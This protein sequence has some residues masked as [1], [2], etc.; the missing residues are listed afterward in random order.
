VLADG[1]LLERALKALAA[2]TG[3]PVPTARA[4]LARDIR[5]FQPAGVLITQGLTQLLDAVARFVEQ[6]GTLTLDARPEPPLA[7]D[8]FDYLTSPGADLVNALG[9]TATVSR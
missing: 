5:R 4:N 3:Q 1:S 8:R 7:I 2:T 6:G 9:L